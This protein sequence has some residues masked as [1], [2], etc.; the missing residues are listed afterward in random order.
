LITASIKPSDK[1]SN[2]NVDIKIR[3][4]NPKP[5]K[6]KNI[7]YNAIVSFSQNPLDH[8]TWAQESYQTREQ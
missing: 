6:W 5:G 2:G 4:Y 1:S 8:L 7:T 3:A